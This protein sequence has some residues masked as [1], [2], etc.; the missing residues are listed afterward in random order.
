MQNIRRVWNIQIPSIINGELC[1]RSSRHIQWVPWRNAGHSKWANIRHTKGTKDLERSKQIIKFHSK[2][3]I[4]IRDG[5]G[6]DARYN[7]NLSTV[8]QEAKDSKLPMSSIQKILENLTKSKSQCQNEVWALKG[9]GSAIILV[10]VFTDNRTRVKNDLNT[11]LRKNKG[12]WIENTAVKLFEC[13]GVI[14][15]SDH[16]NNPPTDEFLEECTVHAIEAGAN[17]FRI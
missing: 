2:L 6:P 12:I 9:P 5:G 17:D 3:Q 4:A 14:R 1:G 11:V 8:L 7:S 13:N 10:E 15:C 16:K